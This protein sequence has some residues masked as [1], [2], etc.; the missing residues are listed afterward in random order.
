MTLQRRWMFLMAIGS[1]PFTGCVGDDR[2]DGGAPT[3]TEEPLIHRMDGG[4]TLNTGD[5]GDPMRGIA[6]HSRDKNR[7]G[8]SGSMLTNKW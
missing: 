2:R 7:V 3:L 4:G 6:V 8:C 1:G 5:G